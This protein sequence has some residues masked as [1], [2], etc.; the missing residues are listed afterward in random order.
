[1]SFPAGSHCVSRKPGLRKSLVS[2]RQ[3]PPPSSSFFSRLF[4]MRVAHPEQEHDQFSAL[5]A[6][7]A[8]D[9]CG[10]FLENHLP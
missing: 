4:H 5:T 9:S 3:K 2:L 7:A 8:F 10:P 6:L 1:M